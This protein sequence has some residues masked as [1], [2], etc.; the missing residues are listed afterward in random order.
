[1]DYNFPHFINEI[2]CL[3]ICHIDCEYMSETRYQTLAGIPSFL[4][5]NTVY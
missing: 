1:M 4:V 2:L 3:H 5:A